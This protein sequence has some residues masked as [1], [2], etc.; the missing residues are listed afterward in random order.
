MTE[1]EIAH[2]FY[3]Y[4]TAYNEAIDKWTEAGMGFKVANHMSHVE[5]LM[6]IV[7]FTKGTQNDGEAE[8]V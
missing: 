4:E 6:A 7:K 2:L 5:A 1:R 8:L 3:V